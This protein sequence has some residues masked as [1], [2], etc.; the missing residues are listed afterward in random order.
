MRVVFLPKVED[1]LVE[2]SEILY[3]KEYFGFRESAVEYITK[4]VHDINTTLHSRLKKPAPNYFNRYGIG[5]YYASFPKGKATQWYVFFT[6][7]KQNGETIYLVRY[8]T[9]NHVAAQYL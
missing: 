8:I 7:Y 1:Y 6:Q 5:M 2:L 4:L 9:N 3:Q